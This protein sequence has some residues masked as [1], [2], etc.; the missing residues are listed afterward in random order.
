LIFTAAEVDALEQIAKEAN[1]PFDRAVLR[2]VE[3]G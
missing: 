1:H 3:G 2:V